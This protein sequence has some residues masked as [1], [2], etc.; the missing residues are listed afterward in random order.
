MR[1]CITTP[2]PRP[3]PDRHTRP[4]GRQ[5]QARATGAAESL[6]NPLSLIPQNSEHPSYPPGMPL[7]FGFSS[8]YP[9][10]VAMMNGY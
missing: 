4:S 9:Q 7:R 8:T 3:D 1:C 2:P 5:V 6:V 10:V